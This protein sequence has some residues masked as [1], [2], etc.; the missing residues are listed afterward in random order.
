M[1]GSLYGMAWGI[2]VCL[3]PCLYINTLYQAAGAAASPRC[4]KL[5]LF[6]IS[7]SFRIYVVLLRVCE[8]ISVKAA[9]L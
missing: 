2:L 1:A 5:P 8:E 9:L 7:N 6:Q 3:L 4:G